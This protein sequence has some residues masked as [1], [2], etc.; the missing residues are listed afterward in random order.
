MIVKRVSTLLRDLPGDTLVRTPFG[1]GD[2]ALDDYL[3]TRLAEVVIHSS[4]L[5]VAL[6]EGPVGTADELQLV[7]G[8]L[9]ELAVARGNGDLVLRAMSGRAALPAGFSALG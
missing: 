4:D 2:M 3:V 7:G 5:A 6:G 1:S 9:V 8:L